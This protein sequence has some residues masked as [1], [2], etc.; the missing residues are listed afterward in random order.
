MKTPEIIL[1]SSSPRRK[2][3]LK[4]LGIRFSVHPSNIREKTPYKRPSA[5]V[6]DLALQKAESVAAKHKDGL[7]VGADTIV[8]LN[9]DII[10]KPRDRGDALRM[11]RKLS[12]SYH[13]VYTG[14]AVIDARTGKTATAFE[15]SKVKMR[16][17]GGG[18][19]KRLSGKHMDKAG[20]YAV[21][22]KD[23][24]FVENI[25]GDYFNVVGLPV[26]LLK[27]MLLKFG[28]R[29]S[30]FSRSRLNKLSPVPEASD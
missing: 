5:I 21:Q 16:S 10:G 14:L 7:V 4:A 22:E 13:R 8:V 26:E 1:A 9:G 28:V 15:M 27:K 6:I 2:Q 19:L 11:L 29:I 20:A 17:L 23:D 24:A 18:E 12:G 30:L 3:L 25:E